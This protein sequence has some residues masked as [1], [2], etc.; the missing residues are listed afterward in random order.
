MSGVTKSETERQ[1][2]SVQGLLNRGI[3]IQKTLWKQ[4][5]SKRNPV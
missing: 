4:N 3:K 5:Q 2:K 1:K